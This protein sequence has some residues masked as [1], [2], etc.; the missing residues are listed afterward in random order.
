MTGK[1]ALKLMLSVI[2]SKQKAVLPQRPNYYCSFSVVMGLVCAST[3][4]ISDYTL[5][6]V[7]NSSRAIAIN[8]SPISP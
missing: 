5:T 6:R 3:S 7:P 2:V 8:F 4:N 1:I